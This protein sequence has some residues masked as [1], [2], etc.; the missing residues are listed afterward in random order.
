MTSGDNG[1]N[2]FPRINWPNLLQPLP[3]TI[4]LTQSASF[5]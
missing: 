4:S 1:F 5:P 3:P 2:Y